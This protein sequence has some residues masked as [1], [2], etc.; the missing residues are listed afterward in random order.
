[1]PNIRTRT[2]S[3]VVALAVTALVL[4][5]CSG[6]GGAPATGS[7]DVSKVTAS[8]LKGTTIRL[9]RVFG[10]CDKD[11]GSS[12]DLSTA[13]GECPAITMLTN[14]FNKTNKYGITV[15]LLGNANSD[16]YYDTLNSAFAGGSP[17]DVAL[18]H[19]S[20]LVDYA[21]RGL[22]MPLDDLTTATGI[23]LKD[24]VPAAKTNISYDGKVYA[25]PFDIHGGL[26]HLN[27]DLWKKA[28]LTSADGSPK[29]PTS[30]K[31]FLADAKI[32]RQKTGK[33]FFATARSG[34]PF[35]T[36]LLQSLV[37][38]QGSEILDS[39]G[40]EA[41]VDTPEVK[42]ALSFM[43]QVFNGTYANGKLTYDAAQQQFLNG[44][45]AMLLNGTWA[46]NDYVKG[47]KF[48]YEATNFP[49]LYKQPAI[50][51]DGH[52]WAIPK[53]K[54]ADPVK[55]RAALEF[56]KFLYNHDG[57]WAESTGHISARTSVLNS[58]A[59]KSAPQRANYAAT[60]DTNARPVPRIPNWGAV[61]DAFQKTAES[62]WFEGDNPDAAL[63]NGN[64]QIDAILKQ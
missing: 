25:V 16:S 21:R 43:G 34:D 10:V 15:K 2:A 29:L 30:T 53:Q 54:N 3:G 11:V 18:V 14:I 19:G 7:G 28:G 26:A 48:K 12:T 33:Y 36:H 60:G 45:V 9:S 31:E 52:N 41:N 51:A 55:Y 58:A 63:K 4:T 13:V 46:V 59:Y 64:Q 56:I 47:V 40:T 32:V 20:R 6:G 50:W 61:L 57:N 44:D 39:K 62:V 8:Q 24:A 5:A 42:N 27:L 17:A 1:M 38:Q 23:D 35:G 37:E 49:T 22:L